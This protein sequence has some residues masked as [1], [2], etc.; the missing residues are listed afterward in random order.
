LEQR[1]DPRLVLPP[2][3][4]WMDETA[5]I[6]R[7]F[8]LGIKGVEALTDMYARSGIDTTIDEGHDPL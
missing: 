6:T 4:S 8:S 7:D 3:N 1:L 2:E 5:A